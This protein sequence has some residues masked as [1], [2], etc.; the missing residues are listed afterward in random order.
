MLEPTIPP[1]MRTTSAVRM[2]WS[3]CKLLKSRHR[4]LRCRRQ[5]FAS[6]SVLR[7][8]GDLL[9][10]SDLDDL[11]PIH[12][13]DAGREVAHDWHGVRDKQICEAEIAL[14]LLEKIHDLR[15]DADIESGNR[16]IGNNKL[17]PQS[18]SAG[19]TNALALASGELVRITGQSGVIHSHG[20]QK[21]SHA[22]AAGIAAEAFMRDFLMKNER[23]GD[24][25]LYAV[26]RVKRTKRVLED[27]LHVAAKTA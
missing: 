20:T 22:L 16:F 13:G 8:G 5:Q 27:D 23:L 17:R 9:R 4:H 1:P 10:V 14:E 24:H 15:A 11:A 26:A 21:F 6:V 19:D 3:N 7:S 25:I 18:Q 2:V 12:H